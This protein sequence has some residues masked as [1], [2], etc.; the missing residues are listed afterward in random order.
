MVARSSPVLPPPTRSL[1]AKH[2]I[3]PSTPSDFAFVLRYSCPISIIDHSRLP[4]LLAPSLAR[5]FAPTYCTCLLIWYRISTM[6][7]NPTHTPSDLY[8]HMTLNQSIIRSSLAYV[9]PAYIHGQVRLPICI[10][11]YGTV[12]AYYVPAST[13][14]SSLHLPTSYI[15]PNQ[16]SASTIHLSPPKNAYPTTTTSDWVHFTITITNANS[17]PSAAHLESFL[18]PP[19]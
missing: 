8:S 18:K 13:N 4:A 7:S 12:F 14:E 17:S 5:S 9:L 11:I 1:G 15:H 2:S 3:L 10:C 6:P 16:V 19:V